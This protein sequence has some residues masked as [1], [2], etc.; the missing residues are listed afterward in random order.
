MRTSRV[1]VPV[2]ALALSQ[3]ACT[4]YRGAEGDG[5]GALT[6][7]AGLEAGDTTDEPS[8][9]GEG[10]QSDAECADDPGG[11]VCDEATGL[12]YPQCAPGDVEGCYEGPPATRGVGLCTD[13]TRTCQAS[14][15]WGSC[16]GQTLPSTEICGNAFDENCDGS[17][18]ALDEDG[19]GWTTCDGDCCDNEV[20]GCIDAHLVNPGAFEVPGNGLDDDCD[21]VID[22]VEPSC[23]A[24]LASDSNDGFDYAAAMD[25]CQITDEDAP[26]PERTWG[27]ISA[28][29][30]LANGDSAPLPVQHSIRANFG[31]GIGPSGGDSLVILSSGHAA[32]P[33][34]TAPDHAPFESGQNLGTSVPAPQDWITANGGEFPASCEGINPTQGTDA[35]DSVV[36]TLRVRV[37]TNARSFTTRMFFFSAE[38]PEWVCSEYNDF[39]VALID[40]EVDTNPADKNIA[41]YDDGEAQWPVGLNILKTAPGLFRVCESGNVGCQGDLAQSFH[42]CADGPELLAGTGFD[43]I[44]VTN[45]CN[46]DNFPV[47]GGTGWL[48]MSGNVEPGEIMDI[49][50][51]VWDAGGHL[52]DALVLLDDWRWSLDAA[53]P[54]VTTP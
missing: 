1:F 49:R 39:F 6:F 9:T 32:A 52:F 8:D 2:A 23:D 37:P 11:P 20:F 28:E 14:G 48:E 46:G 43:A 47:G 21:G 18:Y 36:L 45:S 16:L 50:F 33:G 4:N 42:E 17:L 5:D 25:L 12:C 30:T 44:D 3:I 10:C 27:V 22:E 40:S 7:D 41:I 31:D 19:D 35:N 15:A 38:Y 51:A 54:G 53:S 29:L 26:L 34:Q 13:G 24:D